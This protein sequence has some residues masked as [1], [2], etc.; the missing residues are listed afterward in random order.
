[1]RVYF[2]ILRR[3]S[4]RS[5]GGATVQGGLRERQ[6][7]LGHVVVSFC[8]A[9]CLRRR[10]GSEHPDSDF[11]GLASATQNV[12]QTKEDRQVRMITEYPANQPPSLVNYLA[13][14]GDK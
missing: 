13:R 5:A 14:Y 10:G 6:I 3:R 7:C 2:T 9:S 4:E 11:V 12:R 1:R 8:N